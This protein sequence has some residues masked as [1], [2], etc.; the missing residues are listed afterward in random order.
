[1]S[2]ASRLTS[3]DTASLRGLLVATATEIQALSRA[4]HRLQP[5]IAQAMVAGALDESIEEAQIVDYLLQHLDE[6][7]AFVLGLAGQTPEA[8]HVNTGAAGAGLMLGDLKRR[9]LDE[10]DAT[11]NGRDAGEYEPF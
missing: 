8:I 7:S 9:L 1:M 3:Q 11:A 6:L 5:M 2:Q 10:P 4:S